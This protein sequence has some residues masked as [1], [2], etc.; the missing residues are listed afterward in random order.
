MT[1][2][3]ENELDHVREVYRARHDEAQNIRYWLEDYA[4]TT[5]LDAETV[6]VIQ[7]YVEGRADVWSR[8]H[9]V[10]DAITDDDSRTREHSQESPPRPNR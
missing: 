4:K 5:E 6:A 3:P 1:S 10:L 7:M 8:A 2:S 9:A